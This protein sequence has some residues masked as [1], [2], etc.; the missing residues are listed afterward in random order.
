M[1]Y[2]LKNLSVRVPQRRKILQTF[3]ISKKSATKPYNVAQ[4]ELKTVQKCMRKKI[5]Y[6][7]K[8]GSNPDVVGQNGILNTLGHYV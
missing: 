1:V 2:I 8:N 4:Q 3:C 6:A 5:A 7:N